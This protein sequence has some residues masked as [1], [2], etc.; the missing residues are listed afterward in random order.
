V[1]IGRRIQAA[2]EAAGLAVGWD[3]YVYQPSN[4]G[5][6]AMALSPFSFF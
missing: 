5:S 6:C 4:R 1:N 3:G 2:L